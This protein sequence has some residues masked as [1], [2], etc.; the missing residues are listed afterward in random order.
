MSHEVSQLEKIQEIIDEYDN[1]EEI[2]GG[3][4]TAPSKRLAKIYNYDKTADSEHIL[5]MLG[6]D[7]IIDKCPRFGHWLEVFRATAPKYRSKYVL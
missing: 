4:D 5:E 7:V 3:V 2:N 1:P 6:L